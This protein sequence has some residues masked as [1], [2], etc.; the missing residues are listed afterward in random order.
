MEGLELIRQQAREKVDYNSAMMDKVIP[1]PRGTLNGALSA[2]EEH[3]DTVGALGRFGTERGME[4]YWG[5]EGLSSTRPGEAAYGMEGKAFQNRPYKEVANEMGMGGLGTIVGVGARGVN[6]ANF[7]KAES[8]FNRLPEASRTN[9]VRDAIELET[10]W[11]KGADDQW[12]IEISDL[13]SK[14]EL[15]A[16]VVSHSKGTITSTLGKDLYH[17]ELFEAVP[18][19]KNLTTAYSLQVPKGQASYYHPDM[20]TKAGLGPSDL[21]EYLRVSKHDFIGNAATDEAR[22]SVL[23]ETQHSLQKRFGFAGGANFGKELE[24]VQPLEVRLVAEELVERKGYKFDD[25]SP[26]QQKEI[27]ESVR[28]NIANNHYR[29]VLGEDEAFAVEAR[30][31]LPHDQAYVR[32]F[33]MDYKYPRNEQ[34]VRK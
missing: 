16:D 32:P 2:L 21:P 9:Q 24:K 28:T 23:H 22:S 33:R 34:T 1:R 30:R 18:D 27:L 11:F 25:Y 15:P 14:L 17:P 19:L 4:N 12:R 26:A 7:R 10:G 5:Q 6:M 8:Q 20:S 13:G 29:R 31:N 3:E